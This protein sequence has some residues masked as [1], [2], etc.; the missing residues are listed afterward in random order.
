[1]S[2]KDTKKEITTWNELKVILDIDKDPIDQSIKKSHK[3]YKQLTKNNME[4]LLSDEPD[5]KKN[6]NEIKKT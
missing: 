4:K 3:K 1:M 6:Y 5:I 2:D